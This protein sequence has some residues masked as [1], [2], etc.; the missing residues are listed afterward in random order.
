M[1]VKVDGSYESYVA[2]CE[3]CPDFAEMRSLKLRA[4]EVANAHERSFHP[5]QH[6]AETRLSA[7]RATLRKLVGSPQIP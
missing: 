4:L 7:F 6:T 2:W 3:E 5:S 1:T